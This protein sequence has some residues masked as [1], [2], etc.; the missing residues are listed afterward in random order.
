MNILLVFHDVL[1]NSSLYFQDNS[2]GNSAIKDVIPALD[3][4]QYIHNNCTQLSYKQWVN[5]I[6]KA[7]YFNI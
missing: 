3:L 4:F 7:K 2:A 5:S 6:Q 1:G